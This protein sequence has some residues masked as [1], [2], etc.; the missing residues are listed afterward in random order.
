MEDRAGKISGSD[1]TVHSGAGDHH[2]PTH[3]TVGSG[4]FRADSEGGRRLYRIL[5]VRMRLYR[6]RYADL[7]HDGE[8]AGSGNREHRCVYADLPSGW[9][10]PLP[11]F[12][13][14]ES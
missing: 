7:L 2:V 5:A 8:P 3:R 12:S 6:D 13:R 4:R 11:G 14:W 9:C 1:D 10:G